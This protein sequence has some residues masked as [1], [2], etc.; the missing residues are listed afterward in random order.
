[1]P[2]SSANA[3]ESSGHPSPDEHAPH[4]LGLSQLAVRLNLKFRFADTSAV[5]LERCPR[6][7]SLT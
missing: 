1:M 6:C 4:V 3:F 7:D 2:L 5:A